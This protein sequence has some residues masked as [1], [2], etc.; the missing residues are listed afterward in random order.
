MSVAG[1][2][3]SPDRAAAVCR[4]AGFVRI[5]ATA[6]G[7][8][9]AAAGLLARALSAIEVPYQVTTAAIPEAPATDADCT[10]A[11][12]CDVGDVVVRADPLAVEAYGIARELAADVADPTLAAAGAVAAGSE[13]TGEL[14]EAVGLERR[15]GVAVPTD[16]T[17]LAASTLVHADFSGDDDAVA[18][19]LDRLSYDGST[20]ARR[21]LASDVALAAVDGAPE[22]AAESVE[23]AVRPYGCDRFET[24]GGY[25]DVLNAVAQDR[26]GTGIALALALGR[27]VDEAAIETWRDHGRRAHAAIRAADTGRYDGVFV[28]RVDGDAPIDTVARLV[29]AYRSPEPV[30]VAVTDGRAAVVADRPIEAPLREAARTLDG[31]A[32]ARNGRGTASFDG[33]PTDYV[34]AFREAIDA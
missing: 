7:D 24:L 22:R 14:L 30:A 20:D 12:G 33:T 1:S 6:D 5:V 11:V 13:P 10:V 9:L 31:R 28:A 23:R 8:A 32:I 2:P 3:Q 15:P 25:A 19:R 16:P 21:R 18:D 29:G 17:D 26:P 4:S 27:R 34:T